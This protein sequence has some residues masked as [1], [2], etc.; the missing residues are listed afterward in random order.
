V[1]DCG[2]CL[3]QVKKY[4]K[5]DGPRQKGPQS[6]DMKRLEELKLPFTFERIVE[7]PVEEFNDML[8]KT[9]LTEAQ[10]SS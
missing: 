8:T 7:S 2:A 6:R 1:T 4:A 9:K 5:R 10:V 3:L